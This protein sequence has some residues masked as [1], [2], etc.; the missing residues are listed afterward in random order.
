MNWLEVRV[1]TGCIAKTC[2]RLSLSLRWLM[3][4][5][6]EVE[7]M[8][9]SPD[10][11]LESLR[12]LHLWLERTL[13]NTAARHKDLWPMTQAR[14]PNLRSPER[15]GFP[16]PSEEGQSPA[17]LHWV[18]PRLAHAPTLAAASAPQPRA[19]AVRGGVGCRCVWTPVGLKN[20]GGVGKAQ[21]GLLLVKSEF[22][23]TEAYL[24]FSTAQS[25]QKTQVLHVLAYHI[26]FIVTCCNP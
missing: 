19:Y 3:D 13:S 1:L 21:R 8:I 22:K 25:A 14:S 20:C 26:W 23:G 16:L 9:N 6:K 4:A 2:G 15:V 12:W 11:L 24:Q 17:A 10:F 5:L 18:Q 7:N